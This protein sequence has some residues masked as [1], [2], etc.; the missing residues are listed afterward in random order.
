M[1]SEN[2]IFSKIIHIMRDREVVGDNEF[3]EIMDEVID[4]YQDNGLIVDDDNVELSR[5]DLLSRW[6]EY[7]NRQEDLEN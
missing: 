1:I 7:Q 6:E 3:E 5:E 4:E 2:E